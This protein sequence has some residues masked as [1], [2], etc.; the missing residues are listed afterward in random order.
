[1]KIT[2]FGNFVARP[3]FWRVPINKSTVAHL[4]KE[5]ILKVKLLNSGLLV[6]GLVGSRER[7]NKLLLSLHFNFSPSHVFVGIA[8]AVLFLD[9]LS[10][11]MT[12]C[13]IL[14]LEIADF[15]IRLT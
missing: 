13:A 4:T 5:Q 10:S 8:E 1:M 9:Y 2:D 12:K 6:V 11:K 14:W 3:P 7:Y 15:L